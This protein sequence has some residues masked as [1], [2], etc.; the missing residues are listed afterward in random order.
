[1]KR[2]FTV[3][4]SEV[5]MICPRQLRESGL[6]LIQRNRE[7]AYRSDRDRKHLS[8]QERGRLYDELKEKIEREGFRKDM[9]IMVM[10]L[11]DDGQH[12]KILQGHHRL[13]IAIELG[14][15]AVPV[16]FVY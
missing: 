2:E 5:Y 10:L 3:A 11:R 12:D 1:M 8:D 13:S 9:P 14:L 7:N 15:E 16:R 6:E 4:S